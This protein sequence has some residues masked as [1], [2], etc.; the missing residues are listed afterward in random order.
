MSHIPSQAGLQ[1]WRQL[2]CVPLCWE[3]TVG[4][5]LCSETERPA[6]PHPAPPRISWG[7]PECQPAS[8]RVCTGHFRARLGTC[9]CPG[10]GP[11]RQPRRLPGPSTSRQRARG[12]ETGL[13]AS[14]STSLLLHVLGAGV[15]SLRVTA[16]GGSGPE[17]PAHSG[18]SVKACCLLPPTLAEVSRGLRPRPSASNHHQENSGSVCR[19]PL[20][21]PPPPAL[22]ARAPVHVHRPRPRPRC[23]ARPPPPRPTSAAGFTVTGWGWGARLQPWP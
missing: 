9:A 8:L 3:H 10:P 13:R 23:P 11:A 2:P 22:A 6:L 21:L 12:C 7:V 16:L 17:R 14:S 18:C 20:W 4:L 19:A 1:W 15:R 5:Q